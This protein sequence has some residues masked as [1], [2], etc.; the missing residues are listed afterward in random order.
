MT[1][2]EIL[3]AMIAGLQREWVKVDMSTFG[4]VYEGVC[5]GC[6]ATNA[7][8]EIKGKTLTAKELL[9]NKE[10]RTWGDR[11]YMFM[12]KF[13]Y[14]ID[15]LRTGNLQ[16]YNT[17]AIDLHIG[18]LPYPEEPLPA[19]TQNVWKKALPAYIDFYNSLP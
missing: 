13:E 10:K 4:D 17:E 6:A 7:I 11:D 12:N 5:Y 16:A 8:C 9:N 18:Q 19:L 15:K 1:G 2:K 3:G 14:A